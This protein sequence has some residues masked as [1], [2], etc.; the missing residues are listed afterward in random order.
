MVVGLLAA[1]QL[2]FPSLSFE[3]PY[4]SFGRI[5]PIHTNA[6]IFAF[7]GNGIFTGVYYSLQRLCKA[8]MFNDRLSYIHFWAGN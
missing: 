5:R 1:L 4:T 8:R 3:L 6:V 7:V 2:V